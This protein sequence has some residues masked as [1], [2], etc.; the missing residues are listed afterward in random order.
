MIRHLEEH[1]RRFFLFAC[2]TVFSVQF[3]GRIM[4]STSDFLYGISKLPC[5]IDQR[6]LEI[7]LT[8]ARASLNV[9]ILECLLIWCLPWE[10]RQSRD[11]A[12]A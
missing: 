12:K 5:K 10:S 9:G 4:H 1:Q 2:M 7:L 3:L 11:I 8:N 6:E